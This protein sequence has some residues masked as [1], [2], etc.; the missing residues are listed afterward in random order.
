MTKLKN[1]YCDKIEVKNLNYDKTKKTVI[2]T[3]LKNLN[4]TKL[5]KYNCKKLEILIVSSIKF[6]NCDKTLER[7]L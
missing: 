2:V 1:F 3:K 5:K 7:K 4:V 6:S